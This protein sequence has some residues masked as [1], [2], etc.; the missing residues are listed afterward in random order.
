VALT[1]VSPAGKGSLT[2]TLVAGLGPLFVR[3]TVKLIVS[4]TLGVALLT[5]LVKARSACCG[6]TVALAVLLPA[7]GSNWSA[8]LMVAVLVWAVGLFTTA[9]TIRVCAAER[10][11]VPTVQTPP[12]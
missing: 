12:A 10:P 2:L 6:V 11:T 8:W 5:V 4:P 1:R 3:V 9:V 7:F